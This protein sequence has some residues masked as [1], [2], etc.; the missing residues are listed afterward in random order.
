[1]RMGELRGWSLRLQGYLGPCPPAWATL[2]ALEC[3]NLNSNQLFGSIPS[4]MGNLMA[5]QGLV[6]ILQ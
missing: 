3:L 6:P 1:M 4:S 5:L 2:T